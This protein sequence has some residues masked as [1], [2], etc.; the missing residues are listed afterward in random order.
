MGSVSIPTGSGVYIDASVFV[1]AAEAPGS[2]PQV[3]AVFQRLAIGEITAVT[4]IM[5]LAEL[6]VGPL[7]MRDL[8]LEELYLRQVT[9]GPVMTVVDVTR[10]IL[11]RAAGIRAAVKSAKLPD[12]IHAATAAV[13]GCTVFLTNDTRLRAA[14][15][16]V[17]VIADLA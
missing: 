6:L 7:R 9:T 5:T 2:Y 3:V 14:G 4:S 13:T 1:Y 15:V 17:V 11:I 16:P 8:V 10:E 12:A